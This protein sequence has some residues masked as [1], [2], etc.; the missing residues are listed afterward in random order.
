M[1][2]S[3][4]ARIADCSEPAYEARGLEIANASFI[5]AANPATVLALLDRIDLL[6]QGDEYKLA[7]I[8]TFTWEIERLKSELAAA[9]RALNPRLWTEEMDRAW[10]LN[11]PDTYKAFE[12]I[13][14]AAKSLERT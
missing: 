2:Y 13:R 1:V 11:I 12:A 7:A 9:T 6:E 4:R 3:E 5:A 10:H 8:Q 14:T